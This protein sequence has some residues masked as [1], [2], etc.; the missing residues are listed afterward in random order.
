VLT[1]EAVS[2]RYAGAATPSLHSVD[3][4]MTNGEVVGLVGASESGKST[5]C[6]VASGLAPRTIRGTL[7]GRVL[8]DGE[9]V[10]SLP[11]H[12][13]VG[14]VGVAFQN[15][16]SQLSGVCATVYE[17]IAF[18]PMNLGLPL[19][20]VLA[21]T[22]SSLDAMGISGLAERDPNRLSGGQMQLVALAGL[23]ALRPQHLLLDEPTAQLDP[24][25]TQLVADA[26][27]NLAAGGSSILIAEHKTDLIARICTRALCLDAGRIALDG[28]TATVMSDPRLATLGVAEPS[29]VRLRRLAAESDVSADRIPEL[30]A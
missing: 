2:Y 30:A 27:A 8:I 28:P 29:L 26:L 13:L 17:E 20:D 14:K 24:A 22:S 6:L 5:L 11:M 12:L 21:R 1:L 16:S 19:A 4:S 7:T 10:A 25:G 15:P 23:L 18:G 3:V 9:D